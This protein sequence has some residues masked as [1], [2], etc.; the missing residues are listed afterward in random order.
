M[1]AY[2]FGPPTL[3]ALSARTKSSVPR[4]SVALSV[5]GLGTS[6]APGAALDG[7]R[8]KK[9]RE[10]MPVMTNCGMTMKI[11]WVPYEPIQPQFSPRARKAY[12]SREDSR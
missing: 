7:S 2:E 9:T 12:R 5:A 11:L 8:K 10:A 1:I 4:G 3:A 6:A